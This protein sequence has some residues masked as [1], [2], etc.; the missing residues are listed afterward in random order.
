MTKGFQIKKVEIKKR[1]GY[2]L[3]GMF[4]FILISPLRDFL[5]GLPINKYLLGGLGILITL[6]FFDFS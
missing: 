5:D 1:A 2:I 3:L 4:G 6:Y